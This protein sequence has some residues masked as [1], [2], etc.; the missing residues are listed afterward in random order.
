MRAVFRPGDVERELRQR[1]TA[2]IATTVAGT[3]A[4]G[5]PPLW[6]TSDSGLPTPPADTL[7]NA[8]SID[9][10]ADL[11]DKRLDSPSFSFFEGCCAQVSFRHNFNLEASDIDPSRL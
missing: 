2:R 9:D 5:P 8:A 6:V 4:L 10:P 3:N 1:H 11:S 7:P